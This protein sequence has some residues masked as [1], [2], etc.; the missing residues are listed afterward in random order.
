MPVAVIFKD[1]R[2]RRGIEMKPDITVCV[3]PLG[4]GR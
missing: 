3:A 1:E 4:S 2:L